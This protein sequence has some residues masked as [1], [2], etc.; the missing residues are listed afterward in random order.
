VYRQSLIEYQQARRT[1]YQFRD[2]VSQGLRST[3]RQTRLNEINFELRRAAVLVAIS[4][5]DLTQLR[6][7]Q[8]PA[9]AAPGA[10]VEQQFGVT[11]AR[12]LVQ[13]LS[14]LLNVQNDFLSVWVNYEVQRLA[15]DHDLGIMELD[16]AGLRR[17][18][19]VPLA[20]FIAGAEMI[21]QKLCNATDLYPTLNQPNDDARAG[22]S[23]VPSPL[24]YPESVAP[25]EAEPLPAPL[26]NPASDIEPSVHLA[27]SYET[28]RTG[29]VIPAYAELPVTRPGVETLPLELP[30]IEGEPQAAKPIPR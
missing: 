17:E 10:V 12:D 14:D 29:G 18:H 16:E 7:S 20:A 5:V 24:Q 13:S 22:E 26:Q 19:D 8:P 3:L 1:Y 15:L 2:R 27:S 9:P 25:G 21:R 6:L 28:P 11:T 30:W 23:I 4:Q